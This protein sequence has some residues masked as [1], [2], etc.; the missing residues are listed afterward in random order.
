[1]AHR[2]VPLHKT[3]TLCLCSHHSYTGCLKGKEVTGRKMAYGEVYLGVDESLVRQPLCVPVHVTVT[4]VQG[5]EA[6]E[7]HGYTTWSV[8]H[9]E[10]RLG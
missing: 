3:T 4:Q 9:R 1:M 2:E 10:V 7:R 6:I 8:A 5:K